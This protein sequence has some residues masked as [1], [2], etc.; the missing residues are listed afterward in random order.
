MGDTVGLQARDER[1]HAR[2]CCNQQIAMRLLFTNQIR[3]KIG[4]MFGNPETQ[5]GGVLLSSFL[6]CA[7]ISAESDK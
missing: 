1:S 5:P 4:V 2:H 3:E 7:W 6:P